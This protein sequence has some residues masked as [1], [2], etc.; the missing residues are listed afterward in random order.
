V[1]SWPSG[2]AELG[3]QEA[4]LAGVGD[5]VYG[6]DLIALL[7]SGGTALLYLGA[8]LLAA[9]AVLDLHP[10]TRW[11]TEIAPAVREAIA[12]D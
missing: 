7:A 11:V 1:D 9:F 10:R 12:R 8:A 6:L 4:E 2:S 5:H 3:G